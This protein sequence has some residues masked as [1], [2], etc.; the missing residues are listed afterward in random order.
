MPFK[1]LALKH[2]G[3]VNAVCAFFQGVIPAESSKS[4]SQCT[5]N[6]HLEGKTQ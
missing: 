6:V 1:F 5:K 4:L 3:S 2:S